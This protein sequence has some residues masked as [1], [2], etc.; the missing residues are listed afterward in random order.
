MWSAGSSP[1]QVSLDYQRSSGFALRHHECWAMRAHSDDSVFR[2]KPTFATNRPANAAWGLK[3]GLSS[4]I[5]AIFRRG[6]VDSIKF[7]EIRLIATIRLTNQALVLRQASKRPRRIE[8]AF[9]NTPRAKYI[10]NFRY[11]ANRYADGSISV[12]FRASSSR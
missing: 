3:L 12:G 6:Y 8:I 1:S 2:D 7:P 10:S 5:L 4:L 11:S 9:I